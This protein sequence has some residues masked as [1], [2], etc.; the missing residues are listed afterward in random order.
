MPPASLSTLAVMNPGPTTART[1]AIRTRHS[2]SQVMGEASVVVPQHRDDVV[3]GDDS[4]EAAVLVDDGEGD[5]VVF[6][7]ERGDLRLRRVGR[8][9]DVRLAQLGKLDAGRGNRNLHQRHAAEQ[10]LAG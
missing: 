9:G 7:E 2:L 6:V 1:R 4:G 5:E 3:G 10:L 8:A